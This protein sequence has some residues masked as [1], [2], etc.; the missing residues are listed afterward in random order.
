VDEQVL[1][2]VLRS[3]RIAAAGLDVFAIEP[4]PQGNPL[5]DLDNVILTPH[6]AGG[7]QGWVNSFE[8]IAENLRRVEAGQPIMLPLTRDM[9]EAFGR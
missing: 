6:S 1:I 2:D 8:R 9:P 4:V 5:L 3:R 7:I